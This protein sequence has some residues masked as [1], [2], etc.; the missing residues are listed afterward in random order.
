VLKTEETEMFELST[1]TTL[2][3][4]S[5]INSGDAWAI[6][7]NPKN[8]EKSIVPISFIIVTYKIIIKIQSGGEPGVF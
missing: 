4:L 3:M 7:L 5:A 1:G 2:T 8:K 6:P